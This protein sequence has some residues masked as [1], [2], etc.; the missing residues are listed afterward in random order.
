MAATA[1]LYDTSDYPKD[2]PLYSATNKKVLGKIK[3]ECPGVPIAENVGLR[4]KMYS[5]LRADKKTIRTAKG[6]K[7]AVVK[8]LLHHEQYKEA[9]FFEEDLQTRHGH[10]AE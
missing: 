1:D 3:D 9:I 10:V 2:H 5:I 6:V 8:K 7:R 4:P